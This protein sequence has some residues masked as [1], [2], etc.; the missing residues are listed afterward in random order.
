[1]AISLEGALELVPH[2]AEIWDPSG[3]ITFANAAFEQYVGFSAAEAVGTDAATL[4]RADPAQQAA[5]L[6]KLH[7]L[8]PWIGRIHL[9]HKSGARLECAA[10][11]SPVRG[12][13]GKLGAVVAYRRD[14]TGHALGDESRELYRQIFQS[15]SAIK[16]LVDPET[17]AIVDANAAAAR[18]YGYPA[19]VLRTMRITDI[20]QS[21]PHT[22]EA[23]LRATETEPR[24]F[25]APHRLASGE[26]R[27]VEV[28]TGP[29][30]HDGRTL[31]FSIIQDVSD[32]E[33][34]EAKLVAQEARWRALMEQLPVGV[35]VHRDGLV[36]YANRAITQILGGTIDDYIGTLVLDHIHPS[37]RAL[38]VQRVMRVLAGNRTLP[39]ARETLL[40]RDGTAL[41]T[42]VTTIPITVDGERAVMALVHDVSERDQLE[43]QLR[44]AQRM[45]AVG[46]L[47]GGIAHDFNNLLFVIL[48]YAGFL[49]KKL[50]SGDPRRA[51]VAQ[52]EDAGNRAAEL[53]RQLLLFARGADTSAP[54]VDL[55]AIVDDIVRLLRG[56]LGEQVELDVAPPDA[57]LYVKIARPHLEQVL[58]NLA[59]NARDAMPGGGTITILSSRVAE[60]GAP[61]VR[62][63]VR[64]TGVGMAPDVAAHAFEPFFSTKEGRGTGLGLA[65]TY[66]IVQKA[67]GRILL[68]SALGAGTS[69]TI[70]LPAAERAEEIR[71]PRTP[72]AREGNGEVILVVEDEPAVRTTIVRVLREHGY[73]VLAAAD[74]NDAL[75]RAASTGRIDLLLTD[76][77][78]PRMSGPELA[79]RLRAVRPTLRVMYVSGYAGD[80]LAE[81]GVAV[82]E[83]MYKPFAEAD[84]LDRVRAALS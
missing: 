37:S 39:T 54:A 44:S 65:I 60:A 80:A 23:V 22:I 41:E 66:G 3:T 38:A 73:E 72:I 5:I 63:F 71:E 34:V 16:L 8:E 4:L 31:L 45:E 48:S 78:M 2:A 27:R 84:L 6:R 14:V 52:I 81:R 35:T 55:G 11:V 28:F 25:R 49:A 20:N 47:A 79:A 70:L 75:D 17:A 10:T 62:L 29:F 61:F 7:Q 69:F 24:V 36:I 51:D 77:I 76:V 83:V 40:K 74:A 67:G 33:R 46:R 42:E 50:P 43:A 1:M 82:D 53:T 68:E 12:D 30:S 26:I 57:P 59:V 64:D 56:T 58:V 9:Q 32:R 15:N 18:F 13:D 19:D 21:P